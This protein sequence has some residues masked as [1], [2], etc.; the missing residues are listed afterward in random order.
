M[1]RV[2]EVKDILQ[3]TAVLNITIPWDL[4]GHLLV[5]TQVNTIQLLV[6]P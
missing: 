2:F 3:A 5:G 6:A 4:I 1:H